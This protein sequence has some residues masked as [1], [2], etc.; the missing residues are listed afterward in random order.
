MTQS[1]RWN[2]KRLIFDWHPEDD[3]SGD[4]LPI[5]ELPS[6][7]RRAGDLSCRMD[8]LPDKDISCHWSEKPLSA[9]QERDWRIF[10]EDF[11][12][13]TK[14]GRLP[15]PIR[16]WSES[17]IST[18][19]L[20]VLDRA[21][22]EE[23]TPIQRQAIPIALE[24]RDLIGLAETGSGKTLA[25]LIPIL[26]LLQ[27]SPKI[28][29]ETA[30][31]GPY[32]LIL[33]PTRELALQIEAEAERFSKSLGF[34]VA[35]IIGGHTMAS[36]GFRLRDGV[37]IVIATPGRLRDCLE[38]RILTL[39]RCSYVVMD[40]A[41]RLVDLGF[42]PD[43]NFILEQLPSAPCRLDASDIEDVSPM[44]HG[45][46]FRQTTMFSATMPPAVERLAKRY[47]RKPATVIVGTVGLAVGTVELRVEMIAEDRKR[48]RLLEILNTI[49]HDDQ[50]HSDR[51][52]SSHR[53]R[54]PNR[55][56]PQA[57]SDR[58]SSLVLIF[59]NLK[60][61]VDVLC[62]FLD[63]RGYQTVGIH[64]GKTQDAREHALGR[65]RDGSKRIL[66]ATDVASR[67]LDV[68]DLSTVINYDMSKNIEGRTGR[69]GRYGLA[70][71]FLTPE[72]ADIYYDLRRVIEKSPRSRVPPELAA[73]EAASARPGAPRTKR[74]SEETIYA[75]GQ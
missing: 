14:G 9:M 20:R 4:M 51:H 67:G 3:T 74:K 25:F 39:N 21:G 55:D 16:K 35:S 7:K 26:M 54:G 59:V 53:N 37:E 43:L 38:Q 28:I 41:D 45:G 57:S 15:N 68:R 31:D 46:T 19:I 22:F 75:S 12:L 72:D 44:Q 24:N 60:R 49:D 69:A 27:K 11:S 61:T 64:G 8:L 71:T 73:H 50:D 66:I 32:A 1:K 2:D 65:L 6:S 62:K 40:E 17:G 30:A 63:A 33:A 18:N 58:D 5:A 47:L 56:R 52:N 34:R 70:I 23:P 48:N 13:S 10:K 42:E 36:Q 29:E